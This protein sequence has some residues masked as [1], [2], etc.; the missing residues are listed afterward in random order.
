MQTDVNLA[1]AAGFIDADGCICVRKCRKTRYARGYYYNV[2]VNA[3]NT[4]RDPLELLQFMFGGEI[5]ISH[6]EKACHK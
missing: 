1:Y 4:K 3:T 2:Y 6:K 5:G